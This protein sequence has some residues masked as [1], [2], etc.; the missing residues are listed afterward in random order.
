VLQHVI[1]KIDFEKSL[2]AHTYKSAIMTASTPNAANRIRIRIL[3]TSFAAHRVDERALVT[4]IYRISHFRSRLTEDFTNYSGW[5]NRQE[6]P[7]SSV[8]DDYWKIPMISTSLKQRSQP[9]TPVAEA[10]HFQPVGTDPRVLR[11]IECDQKTIAAWQ[12]P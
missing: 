9:D 7:P 4:G 2:W 12:L 3:L 10:Q 5:I 11:E 8:P 6:S 1:K